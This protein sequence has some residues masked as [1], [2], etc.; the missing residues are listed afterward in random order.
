MKDTSNRHAFATEIQRF[1]S[2]TDRPLLWTRTIRLLSTN[3]G[4]P[5]NE[6]HWI[7]NRLPHILKKVRAEQRRAWAC[8]VASA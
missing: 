7:G 6:W 1:V 2:E 4:V 3:F 8:G 5:K